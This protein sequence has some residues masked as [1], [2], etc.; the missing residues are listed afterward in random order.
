MMF[1]HL[2]CALDYRRTVLVIWPKWANF[3]LIHGP[4][5]FSVACDQ[6]RASTSQEPTEEEAE[7]TDIVLARSNASRAKD[8]VSSVCHVALAWKDFSL[9]FRAV[10]ACDA[11]KSLDTLQVNNILQ[12]VA[13]FGFDEV[14]PW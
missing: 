5:A 9:W 1:T 14:Q 11:E 3:D 2:P 4:K 8:V 12:A 6:L 13:T 7:L 10:R